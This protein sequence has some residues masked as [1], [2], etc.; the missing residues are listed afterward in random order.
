MNTPAK[1]LAH[2]LEA[3]TR[4]DFSVQHSRDQL[5]INCGV[6]ISKIDSFLDAAM[7]NGNDYKFF[8]DQIPDL[9]RTALK[10]GLGEPPNEASIKQAIFALKSI[11][12]VMRKEGHMPFIAEP[13]DVQKIASELK[14]LL[15]DAEDLSTD[16]R[17]YCFNVIALVEQEIQRFEMTGV[18]ETQAAVERLTV[19]INV[20]LS[21]DDQKNPSRFTTLKNL[22]EGLMGFANFSNTSISA[23]NGAAK[24]AELTGGQG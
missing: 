15:S 22:W 14:Q 16:L 23:I 21:A 1:E 11:D 4:K 9:T 5:A 2:L 7:A 6:L 10:A 3:I 18:F 24:L 17:L 19:A 13:E 20:L 8:Q 12:A